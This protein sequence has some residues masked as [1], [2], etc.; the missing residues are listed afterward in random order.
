M[1]VLAAFENL[2][3]PLKMAALLAWILC[4]V[5]H[6]FSHAVVAYWG[7]DDSVKARGYLTLDPTRFIDPINTLLIPA[8]VL[9]MGGFPLPG[10][11]VMIDTSRLKNE[12]WSTYV[13]AAGPASNFLLFLLLCAPL[14]PN[15]GLVDPM[16][17]R[18]PTWVYFVGAMAILNF[19]AVLFNLIPVPPLDGFG[20]IEHKLDYEARWK[21][22]QP[23]V[24]WG[25][26]AVLM[27]V[28]WNVPGAMR[29]FFWMLAW[30][31]DSLGLPFHLLV[32]G[33]RFVFF[34]IVPGG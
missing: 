24:G 33:Y 12:K 26:L 22:R 17:L 31:T 15:L 9:M 20:I 25:C 11:A 23:Q 28:M 3:T 8:V 32:D 16:A 7:G 6:E 21:L 18:Q 5:I 14:H 13:S 2:F 27:L 4:T 19:I 34:D 29:P 1:T 10:A 30:V